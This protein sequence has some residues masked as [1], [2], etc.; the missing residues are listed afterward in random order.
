[1]DAGGGV[2][3]FVSRYPRGLVNDAFVF[4]PFLDR[5]EEPVASSVEPGLLAK[6]EGSEE[7]SVV[8]GEGEM[9]QPKN[10]PNLEEP[11]DLGRGLLISG[12]LPY[13]RMVVAGVD[14][15]LEF[16]TRSKL[17]CGGVGFGA[18]MDMVELPLDPRL[19]ADSEASSEP[20]SPAEVARRA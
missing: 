8:E 19:Y 20:W 2:S 10:V 5:N 11:G 13:S 6:G 3:R 14:M 18:T 16:S 7:N 9:A 17:R 15:S 12:V 1:V 4:E